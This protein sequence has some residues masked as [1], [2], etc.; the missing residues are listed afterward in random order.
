MFIWARILCLL[1]PISQDHSW[2]HHSTDCGS[3]TEKW[4]LLS[5]KKSDKRKH[6]LIECSHF[7][8]IRSNLCTTGDKLFKKLAKITNKRKSH[9][10][11]DSTV[12]TD[13]IKHTAKQVRINMHY[14]LQVQICSW[15]EVSLCPTSAKSTTLLGYWMF[16]FQ[17]WG[18][19]LT[20][21]LRKHAHITLMLLSGI[22]FY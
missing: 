7:G 2:H 10:F 14:L 6:F 9:R 20:Y 5:L 4:N 19:E 18:L 17:N 1:H 11:L 21:E 3:V 12:F 15:S 8:G 16:P 22:S 13:I